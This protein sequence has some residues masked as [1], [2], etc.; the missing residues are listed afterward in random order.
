[1]IK[2]STV[3]ENHND[4]LIGERGNDKLYGDGGNDVLYGD[5]GYD[6]LY[7][8]HGL[9]YLYGGAGSDKYYFS[10]GHGKDYIRET[11]AGGTFDRLYL[12]FAFDD[13]NFSI[14]FFDGD[15]DGR[16]DDLALNFGRGDRV[17]VLDYAGGLEV[18]QLIFNSEIIDVSEYL[19][20]NNISPF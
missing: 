3:Q 16:R 12:D 7:G 9:D 15:L 2:R 11:N 6:Y 1:M 18:E 5:D 17:A 13:D 10:R 4:R 8:G 19:I 20:Q 14:G